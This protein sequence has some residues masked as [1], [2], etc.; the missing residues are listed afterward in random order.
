MI[1]ARI[2]YLPILRSRAIY[3]ALPYVGLFLLFLVWTLNSR[4]FQLCYLPY[5]SWIGGFPGGI[6]FRQ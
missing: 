2:P 5:Q 1:F 4:H 3:A 6:P